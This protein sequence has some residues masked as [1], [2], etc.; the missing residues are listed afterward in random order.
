MSLPFFATVDVLDLLPQDWSTHVDRVCEQWS[1]RSELHGGTSTSLE[2]LG[3]VIDYRLLTGDDIA[4]HLPWLFE[5]HRTSFH[6]IAEEISGMS[7]DPDN[8]VT[9]AVN[10]NILDPGG[11]GYEWHLDSNPVTALLFL[12]THTEEDGGRL[13]LRPTDREPLS[14]TPCAG[15]LAVFDARRCPHRVSPPTQGLR[16]SAP[17]NYFIT[18]QPRHRPDDLDAA[19]YNHNDRDVRMLIG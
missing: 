15:T 7:L 11:D 14:V 13:E 16:I 19:L 5:L 9:S 2:P 18:G 4:E 10:V 17:M 6:R 3:T 1:R 8:A 12:S